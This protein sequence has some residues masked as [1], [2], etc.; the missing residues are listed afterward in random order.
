MRYANLDAKTIL[1]GNDIFVEFKG[2]LTE[3]FVLNEL[4]TNVTTTVFYC[5]LL[6]TSDAADEL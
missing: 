6:Y 2:A 4:K 5:C 3:Q 1:E